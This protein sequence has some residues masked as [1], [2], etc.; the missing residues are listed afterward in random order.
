MKLLPEQVT[1]L[2]ESLEQLAIKYKKLLEAKKSDVKNGNYTSEGFTDLPDNELSSEINS[3]IMQIRELESILK[4][5]TVIGEVACD[6]IVLGSEFTV[7][8]NFFGEEETGTYLLAEKGVK[9]DGKNVISKA[10]PLGE[11]VLGKRENESFSYPV[12]N[13]VFSGVI[14]KIHTKTAKEKTIEK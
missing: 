10:S 9:I 4:T 13:D 5:C 8:V 12:Q 2:N 11:A 3:T 6:T 7:T 14:N 1:K